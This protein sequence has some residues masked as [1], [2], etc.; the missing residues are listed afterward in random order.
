MMSVVLGTSSGLLIGNLKTGTMQ[1]STTRCF[2][3]ENSVIEIIQLQKDIYLAACPPTNTRRQ[4]GLFIVN[5]KT[6][7]EVCIFDHGVCAVKPM[8]GFDP[9]D[10]PFVIVRT[11][12]AIQIF[13]VMSK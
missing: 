5:K 1:A 10:F 4:N 7:E 11:S 6:S 3:L 8:P 13:N 12:N 9:N 2:L